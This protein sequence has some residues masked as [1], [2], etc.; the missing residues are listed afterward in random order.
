VSSMLFA[1]RVAQPIE[2]SQGEI[3]TGVYDPVT[4]TST[5][6]GGDPV[7]LTCTGTTSRCY[8]YG[9]YCNYASTAPLGHCDA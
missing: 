3:A 7:L 5:W 8:H 2:V 1:F 9:S 6:E 4:Q